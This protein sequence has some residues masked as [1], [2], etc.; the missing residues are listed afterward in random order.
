MNDD[1]LLFIIVFVV[2][3]AL[4]VVYAT[5]PLLHMPEYAVVWGWGALVFLA[6][7][8]LVLRRRR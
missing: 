3:A 8:V 5:V 6:L 7:A 2:W 4:A 1:S